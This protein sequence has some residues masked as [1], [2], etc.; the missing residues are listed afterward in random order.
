MIGCGAIVELSHGPALTKLAADLNFTVDQLVDPQSSRTQ[1]LGQRFPHANR[2]VSSEPIDELNTDLAIVA[3]PPKF[4]LSQVRGLLNRGVNVFCEKPL[5]PRLAD[6]ETMVRESESKGKLLAAGQIR[7][8][9][10]ALIE[11]KSVIENQPYGMLRRFEIH[12][13]GEFNWPAATPSFFNPAQAGGGVLLDLGVHILDTLQW[14]LGY[15]EGFDYADDAAGGLEANCQLRLNYMGGISGSVQLSRDS[16]SRNQWVFDF[17]HASIRWSAGETN[18]LATRL[19]GSDYWQYAQLENDRDE[20]AETYNEVF[21]TQ[22][23]DVITATQNGAPP[24]VAGSAALPALRLIQDCYAN[25]EPLALPWLTPKEKNS[26]RR[27]NA[28]QRHD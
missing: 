10:P 4:H 23:R 21:L 20:A 7:R 24:R 5:A 27:L 14:W 9:F 12:E 3:S 22:L 25:R 13:G 28:L 19:H 17:E 1:K 8:F 2:L 18:R 26:L 15:P 16:A 11:I 6:A